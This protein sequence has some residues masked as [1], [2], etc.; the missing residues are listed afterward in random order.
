MLTCI[1]VARQYL[2]QCLRALRSGGCGP[3]SWLRGN[4]CRFQCGDAYGS[5]YIFNT[6]VSHDSACC[7]KY[8][9]GHAQR[10]QLASSGSAMIALAAEEQK[11]PGE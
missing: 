5:V 1:P 8:R 3:T 4:T 6:S 10:L 9:S 2:P 7:R 11:D